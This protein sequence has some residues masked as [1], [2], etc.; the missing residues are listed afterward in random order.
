LSLVGQLRDRR[1]AECIQLLTEY[2][3][4]PPFDAGSPK[5]A[6]LLWSVVSVCVDKKL[7]G[8][9]AAVAQAVGKNLKSD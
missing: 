3:P 1:Y 2:D 9:A 7:L 5:H 8:E 4:K 6:G